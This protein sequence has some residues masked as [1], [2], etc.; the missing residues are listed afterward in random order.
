MHQANTT[1]QNFSALDFL[2]LNTLFNSLPPEEKKVMSYD[3]VSVPNPVSDE[4]FLH[5]NNNDAYL[6]GIRMARYLR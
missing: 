4:V 1:M 3:P 2:F 6:T 5:S